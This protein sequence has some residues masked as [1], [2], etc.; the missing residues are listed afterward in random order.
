MDFHNY[1][2]VYFK[3]NRAYIFQPPLQGGGSKGLLMQ[4]VYNTIFTVI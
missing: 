3:N 1:S 2:S 4:G